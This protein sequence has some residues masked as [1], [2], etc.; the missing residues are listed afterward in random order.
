MKNK[1]GEVRKAKARQ[2]L[3]HST[4][5]DY[6]PDEF[7]VEQIQQLVKKENDK[8]PNEMMD[9][10]IMR[11]W[12][13][14]VHNRQDKAGLPSEIAI[15]AV[16]TETGDFLHVHSMKELREQ[17]QKTKFYKALTDNYQSTLMKAA[18]IDTIKKL[19]MKPSKDGGYVTQ[20]RPALVIKG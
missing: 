16:E 12:N 13:T 18:T 14:Y 20:N 5:T 8:Y 15:A 11:S 19:T 10:K 17:I 4:A 9:D 2:D 7:S 1:E 3:F 6:Q